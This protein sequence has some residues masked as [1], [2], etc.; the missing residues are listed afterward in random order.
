MSSILLSTLNTA[1]EWVLCRGD[2]GNTKRAEM[3][4]SEQLSSYDHSVEWRGGL[5]RNQLLLQSTEDYT[6]NKNIVWCAVLS[7]NQQ[8]RIQ[9]DFVLLIANSCERLAHL[10]STS[11]AAAIVLNRTATCSYIRTCLVTCGLCCQGQ[12]LCYAIRQKGLSQLTSNLA[13]MNSK[14][15]MK[16][17]T[18]PTKIGSAKI[19]LVA[20]ALWSS[21]EAVNVCIL[22]LHSYQIVCYLAKHQMRVGYVISFFRW[23]VWVHKTMTDWFGKHIIR[24]KR[25]MR[26]S[27][28]SSN[29]R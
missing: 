3:L 18:S 21:T 11:C 20:Q 25:T 19:F 24:L 5:Q 1:P 28:L 7:S 29:L 2:D 14:Q 10:P 13:R 4:V 26:R 22:R 9:S 17:R 6:V 27:A 15:V 16:T 12:E 8:R 23:S